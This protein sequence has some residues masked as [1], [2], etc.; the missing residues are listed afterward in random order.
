M[1]LSRL[2][3]TVIA[4]S[5]CLVG[6]SS[7]ASG[8]LQENPSAVSVTPVGKGITIAREKGVSQAMLD[9]LLLGKPQSLIVEF[10]AKAVEMAAKKQQVA[11]GLNQEDKQIVEFKAT[12]YAEMKLRALSTLTRTEYETL[13]DY[14]HLP[15]AYIQFNTERAL[16]DLVGRPE[17]KRVYEDRTL[18][19]NL[20]QSLPL[21][22]Q[23]SAAAIGQ[24]GQGATVAVLDTGVDF[25]NPVF[26]GCTS[27]GV[28]A[29]CKVIFSNNGSSDGSGHGTSM[30]GIIVS[31]APNAKIASY[32]V[33]SGSSTTTDSA[34]INGINWAITNKSFYDIRAI[35]MSLG[36]SVG[37]SFGCDV[38]LTPGMNAR[39]AGILPIAAAGNNGLADQIDCPA[40]NSQILGVGAVYDANV[41][42][43]T[44]TGICSDAS[45]QAD[46]ITCFSNSWWNMDLLAPG[47]VI[48]VAGSS[49]SGTSQA[50]AMASGA[51]VIVSNLLPAPSVYGALPGDS[52]VDVLELKSPEFLPGRDAEDVHSIKVL[53]LSNEFR[54][55]MA[56][57]V[58]QE[59]F[60]E[61]MT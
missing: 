40:H 15:M 38:Y 53:S 50:T 4:L 27:P 61:G 31:I 11:R 54:K 12:Q 10:D 30:A 59:K 45:T 5:L 44:Y 29:G 28:P 25:T 32:D 3:K 42:A 43:K 18:K 35:N 52:W 48:N 41:G 7:A 39:A 23:P 34:V 9:G 60:R 58:S 33:F 19:L 49:G 1:Y 26:G 6:S 8:P 16:N 56:V 47:A 55:V 14:S 17:V 37:G 13:S 2:T 51:A 20:A 57:S 24:T 46:Q 36:R 22:N 21:V